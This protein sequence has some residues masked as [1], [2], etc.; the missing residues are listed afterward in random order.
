MAR[1]PVYG[2]LGFKNRSGEDAEKGVN[3]GDE[4]TYRSFIEGGSQAAAMWTFEGITE[5][6]FPRLPRWK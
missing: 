4:W 5:S 3:V 2:K 1:V 6:N